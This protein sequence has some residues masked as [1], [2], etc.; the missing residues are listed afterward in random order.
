MKAMSNIINWV[1]LIGL[2]LLIKHCVHL[3]ELY[4]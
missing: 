1:A 3:F 2:I 4:Q